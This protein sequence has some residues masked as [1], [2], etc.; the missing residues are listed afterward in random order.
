MRHGKRYWKGMLAAGAMIAALSIH[1]MAEAAFG[2]T[3]LKTGMSSADVK[4]LQSDL[5]QLGYFSAT[6]TGYFGSITRDA[7]VKFQQA[8]GL[9]AD[10]VVGPKTFSVLN[11]QIPQEQQ[12]PQNTSIPQEKP[13]TQEKSIL[14]AN[15]VATAK[16]Y[17]GVPYL[18]GGN[19]PS[20]FDCSGF[21]SYVFAQN[22]LTIPRVSADQYKNGTPVDRSK[23]EVGDLVFFTTTRVG[24]SHLGIYIGDGQFIHASSSQGVIISSLSNS[25]WSARYVG[26]RRYL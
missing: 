13:T 1:G 19:T 7:V 4:T 16:K 15:I 20:G 11:K 18:W 24:P 21:S 14:Q 8:N 17:I 12:N 3:V 25:Y 10:G 9:T 2:D 26:A 6:E 23:L 22:G 5:K